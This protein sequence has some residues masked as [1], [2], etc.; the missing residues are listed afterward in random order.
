MREELVRIQRGDCILTG[1][2]LAATGRS[3][4]HVLPWSRARL[5]QVENFLMTTPS[6]NSKKS[7]SLLAPATL[8]RWL[9]Y[10]KQNSEKIRKCAQAHNSPSDIDIVRSVTHPHIS[11]NVMQQQRPY[12]I[13]SPEYD[14]SER[15]A[16]SRRSDCCGSA[17][18]RFG[19][20]TLGP[21][22]DDASPPR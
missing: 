1:R 7:D 17:H 11:G 3:L 10:L 14:R 22:R 8:E 2:S 13:A 9:R 19:T 5:S 18:R 20:R 4:D 16:D 21:G 15:K 6:V 12:G